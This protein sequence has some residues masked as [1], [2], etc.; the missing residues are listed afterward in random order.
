MTERVKVVV[1]VPVRDMVHA[2]FAYCLSQMIGW[3]VR[4]H[5]YVDLRLTFGNGTLL[6]EQRTFL[7]KDALD[8]GATW[9]VFL[10]SDMSF[11]VNTIELLLRS[12]QPIMAANYST[13]KWPHLMPV[14]FKDDE[15][16]T[17]V[18]TRPD[19]P[20]IEEV[21]A[22]GF[23][24]IAVH[25]MA[26]EA[27]PQPWFY[28]PFDVE[29]GKYQCGEDIWFCRRARE[30][31]LSVY[32]DHELSRQVAHAGVREWTL[33]DALAQEHAPELQEAHEAALGDLGAIVKTRAA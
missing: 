33:E 7:A 24:V 10:D 32:V 5:P 28:T 15:E 3:T 13:R 4:H 20:M 22:T 17:R 25:R 8:N 12:K 11:P 30:A 23:G 31:G 27:V 1:C 9:V 16:Q 26:F 2:S 6:C 19:S 29:R 14:T 21:A 18:Y